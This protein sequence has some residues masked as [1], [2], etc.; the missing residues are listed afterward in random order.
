MLKEIYA[1][2]PTFVEAGE[3]SAAKT[4]TVAKMVYKEFVPGMEILTGK[5]M[6]TSCQ[7]ETIIDP[8][9]ETATIEIE[10]VSDDEI[11]AKLIKNIQAALVAECKNVIA[12]LPENNKASLEGF[13]KL[14][15]EKRSK[16]SDETFRIHRLLVNKKDNYF[17]LLTSIFRP[18]I[19][20][21]SEPF[22]RKN[23]RDTV[24]E[25]KSDAANMVEMLVSNILEE[26]PSKEGIDKLVILI[27]DEISKVLLEAGFQNGTNDNLSPEQFAN[28]LKYITNSDREEFADIP[29]VACGMQSMSIAVPGK[30]IR[31]NDNEI[32][33]YRIIDVVGFNN[34]G[35]G[36]IDARLRQA[37]LTKYN[38]D[39]ILYF[40]SRRA[41]NKMHESYLEAVFKTMRPA[42]LIIIST[43]MDT[44][45]I[46]ENDEYPDENMIR[47]V[48]ERR[49][50]ELLNLVKSLALEDIRV[51]LPTKEDVLCIANKVSIKRNGEAALNVYN[52][53]QYDELRVALG[54]CIQ[55]IRKKISA[56]VTITDNFLLPENSVLQHVG[57]IVN[58]LGNEIDS[59]YTRM[60]DFSHKI[61]HWT[62]DA[63]LWNLLH[64]Y[65]HR[66]N[67]KVWE[68]VTITTFNEMENICRE[69]LGNFKF[70][71]EVKVASK[72]DAN[73]IKNEFEANLRTQLY[74]VVRRLILV[75][76]DNSSEESE[77]K[78]E[79]R[80]LA[81][82]SKYN[83]WKI[84]DDLR[85]CLMKA[86]AQ[87]DYLYRMLETAIY[88]SLQQTYK[89]LLY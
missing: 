70:S 74:H 57:Q 5:G 24:S 46:Y 19:E 60:R 89:K 69:I 12:S 53:M 58:K 43:F 73:R 54:S 18:A 29:S 9:L 28:T 20:R 88:T 59:E 52:E 51:I 71:T 7:N 40:A 47:S 45:E 38:Y 10:I 49:K 22:F 33:P 8:K 13:V 41:V 80:M 82:R 77:Y 65:Q 1:N 37:M 67:A 2:I 32:S 3:S 15:V 79:I 21:A 25:S 17:E 78:R 64:G 75:D 72:E 66:S 27:S 62:L 11:R 68:N 55:T 31:I 56:G 6:T 84:I 26:Y 44:D 35:L 87:Q 30:G 16:L 36:N 34:D 42:K 81:I 83:K 4:H 14:A 61:H 50:V 48:N 76:E 23:Y 85:L 86:V 63:V 39:G